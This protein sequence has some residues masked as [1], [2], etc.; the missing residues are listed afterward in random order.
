MKRI[1]SFL[2]ENKS[3]RQTVAKNTFWM[4]FGE[5][6]SRLLRAAILIYAARILGAAGLGIFSYAITLAAIFT[7]L[8]DIGLSAILT[9]ETAK[10]PELRSKYLST[11]LF[12]KLILMAIS[13]LL[14]I[15]AA[16][17]LTKIEAARELLPVV[18]FILFFDGMREF[19]F[20]LNRALE[21]MEAEAIAKTLTNILIFVLG[22]IFLIIDATP[23]SLALSYTIGSGIGFIFTVWTL[24]HYFKDIIS[25]FSKNLLWPIFSAAWPFALNGLLSGI[26]LNT[27]TVMLGWWRSASELGYYAVSQRMIQMLYL[28]PMLFATSIFPLFAKL[29]Q[30]ENEKFK[31]VLEKAIAISMMLG[32]PLILG[33]LILSKNLILTLFGKEFIFAA[34]SFNIL[35]FTILLIF[36]GVFISNAAFAY[37]QQKRFIGFLALGALGNAALNYFMIPRYGIEGSSLATLGAQILSTGFIWITFKKTIN[38]KVFTHLKKIFIASIIMTIFTLLIQ[39]LNINLFINLGIS[40]LIYFGMLHFIKEQAFSEVKDIFLQSKLKI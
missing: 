23:K 30:K 22:I 34:P 29:A 35:L 1:K 6:S 5:I 18:A 25:N 7:I 33:G 4:F 8:S 31:L 38:F 11:S 9:R 32:L 26:M 21:K 40:A 28:I 16:P 14:I 27:D 37:N 10:N 12:I 3:T 15:F 2:F 20:S 24:R 13:A 39:Y 17:L 19:C 36:P